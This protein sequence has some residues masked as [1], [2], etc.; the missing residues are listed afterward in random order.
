MKLTVLIDFEIT[1]EPEIA[2][3]APPQPQRDAATTPSPIWRSSAP[4]SEQQSPQRNI[5]GV[6]NGVGAEEASIIR[7]VSARRGTRLSFLG[8][9]KKSSQDITNE[10]PL[11]INGDAEDSSAHGRAMSKDTTKRSLFRPSLDN[12]RGEN[13]ARVS[14]ERRGSKDDTASADK[15]EPSPV[16]RGGSVRKRLSM[17]KLGGKKSSKNGGGMM[18]SL[19][20]E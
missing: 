9:K 20:E 10:M 11:H 18:G 1:F 3:F 15:D 6:L 16:K 12:G 13:G 19:D 7:P 2:V 17:L 14:A 5:A 4:S 8:G